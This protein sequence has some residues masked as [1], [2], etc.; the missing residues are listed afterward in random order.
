MHHRHFCF[1]KVWNVFTVTGGEGYLTPAC[2]PWAAACWTG[3]WASWAGG[4][5]WWIGPWCFQRAASRGPSWA[6]PSAGLLELKHGHSWFYMKCALETTEKEMTMG[7]FSSSQRNDT[8]QQLCSAH[9]NL[10]GKAIVVVANCP[11]EQQPLDTDSDTL[12]CGASSW[13]SRWSKLKE[14]STMNSVAP[15]NGAH[16]E[17][18]CHWVVTV[19]PGRNKNKSSGGRF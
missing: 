2:S 16:P 17:L 14:I 4:A 7:V 12:L 5:G 1:L 8:L 3:R 15:L 6:C 10:W 13:T 9:F 19:R 11:Q 18:K